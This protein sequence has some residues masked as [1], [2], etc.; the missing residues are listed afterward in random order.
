[1][2]PYGKAGGELGSSSYELP[3][4]LFLS[5]GGEWMDALR[6]LIWYL[7]TSTPYGLLRTELVKFLYLC[8]VEAYKKFNRSI[9]G[10]RYEFGDFGPFN[11]DILDEATAMVHEGLLSY[12]PVPAISRH[13][14][15]YVFGPP[16]DEAKRMD[17]SKLDSRTLSVVQGVLERFSPLSLDALLDYVYTTPPT[18]LFEKGEI[19]DFGEW[20]PNADLSYVTK[21][22]VRKRLAELRESA[23]ARIREEYSEYE[24]DVDEEDETH[25]DVVRALMPRVVELIEFDESQSA[26]S[27]SQAETN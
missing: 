22:R 6:Q 7:C 18:N 23:K 3:V 12:R 2:S 14:L 20:I 13:R 25:N 24:L 9:T 17:S 19:I 27:E 8:D 26:D 21:S 4:A 10:L 16:R 1:L 11:W 15:G 5:G